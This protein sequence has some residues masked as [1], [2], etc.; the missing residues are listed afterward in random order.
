MCS[1]IFISLTGFLLLKLS[2]KSTHK[3]E[4]DFLGADKL[5]GDF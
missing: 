3:L 4:R 2:A 1:L 5:T